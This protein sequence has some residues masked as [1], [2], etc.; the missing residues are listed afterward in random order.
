VLAVIN[1]NTPASTIKSDHG[2]KAE[3][4]IGSCRSPLPGVHEQ[5]WCTHVTP[6]LT[7]S[8]F[9]KRFW[10]ELRI[11]F[12]SLP[13]E[14]AE[15]TY[16]KMVF[17]PFNNVKFFLFHFFY[18]EC[19]HRRLHLIRG[20]NEQICENAVTLGQGW[21]FPCALRFSSWFSSS[22]KLAFG[23]FPL[24]KHRSKTSKS[25]NSLWVTQTHVEKVNREAT[26]FWVNKRNE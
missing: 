12:T 25:C 26:S 7:T 16:L 17:L 19:A 13:D 4:V 11:V 15:P 10:C 9:L 21:E 24:Q 3:P 14:C 1:R 6:F 23:A 18:F 20:K 8:S 2:S 5:L 22:S